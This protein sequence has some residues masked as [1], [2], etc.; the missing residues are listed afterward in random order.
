MR[1][2]L[3]LIIYGGLIIFIPVLFISVV[4]PWITISE[5]PSDVFRSRSTIENE[6]RRIYIENGC[7]Y[8]HTQFIRSIDWDL[9]AERIARSGDYV[10]E[11]PHLLGSERTGPD[12]SQEGGEHPDDWHMAHYINPRFV[13]PDSIMPAFQ[14]LGLE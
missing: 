12:L 10:S 7:T 13:R 6:G 3:K 8:C 4:L 5:R 9:G 11:Q 1:M 14:H 2:T